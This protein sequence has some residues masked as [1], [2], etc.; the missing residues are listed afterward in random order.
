MLFLVKLNS[1][2]YFYIYFYLNISNLTQKS[3]NFLLK[4]TFKKNQ[5]TFNIF[6]T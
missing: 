4:K 2:N 6:H 5:N 1:M 3:K